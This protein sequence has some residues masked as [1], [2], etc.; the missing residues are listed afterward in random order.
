LLLS[1][2]GMMADPAH[3]DLTTE[4]LCLIDSGE[5]EHSEARTLCSLLCSQLWRK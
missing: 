2:G 5:M 3:E 1:V 4:L